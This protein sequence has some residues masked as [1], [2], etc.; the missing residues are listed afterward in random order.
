MGGHGTQQTQSSAALKITVVPG[1]FVST[2][3]LVTPEDFEEL[4][5]QLTEY[6]RTTGGRIDHGIREAFEKAAI[7]VGNL[8]VGFPRE[9]LHAY[10]FGN[11]ATLL[12]TPAQFITNV[13]PIASVIDPNKGVGGNS[14]TNQLRGDLL[15]KTAK[16]GGATVKFWGKYLVGAFHGAHNTGGLGRMA[17]S[18]DAN[19]TARSL[20]DW[21]LEGTAILRPEKWDFDWEWSALATEL[22]Q[23]GVSLDKNDLRGRQRRT[24]LGSSIPGQRFYVAMT[25]PVKVSQ[26]AGDAWATFYV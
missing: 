16:T 2:K 11:Y 9:L 7:Q 13:G 17:L 12:L 1:G 18:V 24:A 10:I 5:R 3:P 6:V 19:V 21:E 4:A 15:S 22:W 25:A 26:R 23:G 8:P 20:A 14:F